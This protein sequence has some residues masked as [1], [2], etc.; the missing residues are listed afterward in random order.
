MHWIWRRSRFNSVSNYMPFSS[1]VQLTEAEK[2]TN[3]L[4]LIAQAHD[5]TNDNKWH[6]AMFWSFQRSTWKSQ[7]E[8]KCYSLLLINKLI[9]YFSAPFAWFHRPEYTEYANQRVH[10]LI[11]ISRYICNLRNEQSAFSW[12]HSI[13]ISVN[14]MF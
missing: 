14:M 4:I 2:K 11:Y 7:R 12:M 10:T 13:E 8:K 5:S 1:Y 9:C 6:N 3:S